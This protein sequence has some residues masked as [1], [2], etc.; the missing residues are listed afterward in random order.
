M[1]AFRDKKILTVLLQYDYG[2]KSR[3]LSGEKIW[4]HDNLA[5]LVGEVI[6]FWYDG[7]LQNLGP[8]REKIIAEAKR[9]KPDL[10]FFVPYLDQFDETT[11]KALREIA[12]TIA[13][14]GDDHWRFDSF[15]SRLAPHYSHVITTDAWA[16]PK[17]QDIGVQPLLSEWAADTVKNPPDLSN[18]T[19]YKYEISFVGG[20]NE[21]RTWFIRELAKRDVKVE[22]F[23]SG[24][25]NG[26]VSFDQ[27]N[28]IFAHSKINLNLSNSVPQD[29]SFVLGR[30]R[31]FARWATSKK[32]SEQVKARN[33]E[34]PYVGGFQLS[35]YALGLERYLKIGDEVAVFNTVD[36]CAKQIRYYLRNED[37]RRAIA[38]KS[39]AR[40]RSEHT[41][42]HRLEKILSQVWRA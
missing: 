13:W 9:V 1:T 31:Q 22:C 35:K 24:W 33:F 30:P 4:F 15:S 32:Q 16:L 17:Y 23:G 41:Y 25:P 37:E 10:I 8:L 18:Q 12:P 36:E 21:V 27:M 40:V 34:I 14:F 2:D 7:D 6:P 19:S 42:L 5:K 11:L 38:K 28:D 39:M 29:I 20:A 26:R 3:G